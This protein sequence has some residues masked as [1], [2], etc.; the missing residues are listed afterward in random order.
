MFQPA[1][2]TIMEGHS[3]LFCGQDS[4]KHVEAPGWS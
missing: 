3:G 4:S 2:R 1:P